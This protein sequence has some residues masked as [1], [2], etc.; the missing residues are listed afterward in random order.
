MLR[1]R[2]L[3]R[4]H[5]LL[6]P[7]VLDP[8]M[9]S[10]GRNA[11]DVLFSGIGAS[12]RAS[13]RSGAIL[14]RL[15][16]DRALL[17][18]LVLGIA[19]WIG[20]PTVSAR[21]DILS[22]LSDSPGTRW[23]S[24]IERS[25]AGSVQ[26]AEMRFSVD[27]TRTAAISGAGI[28]APGIGQVAFL[29]KS[30]KANEVP[31]EDRINR[32][33]KA[34]RVVRIVPVAP[35]KAFNAGTVLERQSSLMDPSLHGDLKM[36][37]AKPSIKGEE[38]KIAEAFHPRMQRDPA[39]GLPTLVA[40]LVNNDHPDVLAYASARPDYERKSPFESLLKDENPDAGR[41]IP[42]MEPGDHA[43][44]SS[45]LPASVFSKS[46]QQCLTAGV[47]FEARGE[48]VKGQAAVAQ[49]I[50]NRVRNPAYP[51]TVCGVVYQNEDWR[52]GCQFSFACDGVRERVADKH[53]WTIAEDIALAVTAGKIWLPEVGSSTH[54]HATYVHPRW[55][56]AMEKMKK[57]GRHIFYRTYGGGWS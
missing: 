33:E 27:D 54:Y 37:F 57:I 28:K 41:F 48:P 52:N 32:K 17:S 13:V 15:S 55:A 16:H 43:W 4:D 38:I 23:D 25:V 47:Y 35:P 56:R 14:R 29:S 39:A 30:G 53:S 31:D 42:P 6:P 34:G 3:S 18:P 45:P 21:Q 36:A 11:A 22:L 24:Y 2:R 50:L 20:F 8:R 9:A 12:W 26:Q 1:L 49:V 46:E 19:I 40:A 44:V 5:A 51:K 10:V 7:R